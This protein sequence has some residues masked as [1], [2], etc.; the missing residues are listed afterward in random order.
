ME[1]ARHICLCSTDV[2]LSALK[3]ANL[4]FLPGWWNPSWDEQTRSKY[5]HPS[6][7]WKGYSMLMSPFW[8]RTKGFFFP[9][10]HVFKVQ[11][12][13][14][15]LQMVSKASRE[16]HERWPMTTPLLV[17]SACCGIFMPP[18]GWA[19]R[20]RACSLFGAAVREPCLLG[21]PFQCY[22]LQPAQMAW[23]KAWAVET[24]PRHLPGG[25]LGDIM[26]EQ[27]PNASFQLCCYSGSGVFCK[28]ETHT[29]KKHVLKLNSSY[30]CSIGDALLL[31][32]EMNL[33]MY[34]WQ[35]L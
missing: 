8:F 27:T 10:R 13:R 34:H 18:A 26:G 24:D 20:V 16:M 4:W 19:I 33:L 30:T 12:A 21:R 31:S 29:Q 6:A 14:C 17:L 1:C 11:E 35:A 15:G 7:W 25:S 5:L 2:W 32:G 28:Y 9:Q 23:K 22:V 3:N